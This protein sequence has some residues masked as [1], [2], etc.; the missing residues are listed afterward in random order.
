M[1]LNNKIRRELMNYGK[2]NEFE[3]NEEM[4][5]E[6]K[7]KWAG[8]KDKHNN[9]REVI[10]ECGIRPQDAF[11][12]IDDGKVKKGQEFILDRVRIDVRKFKKPIIKIEFSSLIVFEAEDEK[13]SEHEVEV[14]L[15]FKLI[16]VNNGEK[17]LVQSWKYL[18]EIDVE[19]NI[20]ELEVE[21]SQ[22]FTVTF[23]DKPA[24]C[25]YEYI[26]VVEGLDFEGKF[27]ALRVVKPDLSVIAQS[28]C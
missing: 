22:P 27:D 20:D 13:G 3:F 2:I 21:M 9:S 10:L 1:N 14:N 17:E 4:E 23:C 28:Q 12:E 18:Y 5:V 25:I 8:Y 26:M 16:R 7:D 11:F 19:N 15:L 6:Y 24:P